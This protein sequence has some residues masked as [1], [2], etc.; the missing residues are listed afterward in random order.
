MPRF[1]C[2]INI[3]LKINLLRVLLQWLCAWLHKSLSS[4]P[5]S[6]K[7]GK[8]ENLRPPFGWW[9]GSSSNSACLTSERS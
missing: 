6:T 8:K 7:G 1:L 5:T 3:K 2:A 4:N 9:S